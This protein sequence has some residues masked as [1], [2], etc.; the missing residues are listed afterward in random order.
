MRIFFY[1][2]QK[3]QTRGAPDALTMGKGKPKDGRRYLK[4]EEY[5][6]LIVE[7]ENGAKFRIVPADPRRSGVECIE[8]RNEGMGVAGGIHVIPWSS[9]V[10]MVA[11]GD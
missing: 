11:P 6:E 2:P 3:D 8:I 10:V 5:E 9:N 7:F 4:R 1:D